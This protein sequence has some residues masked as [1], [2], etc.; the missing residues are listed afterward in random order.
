MSSILLL[1]LFS[2]PIL[3]LLWFFFLLHYLDPTFSTLSTHEP[4]NLVYAYEISAP[5]AFVPFL[6]Y[7]YTA[8][9]T[10]RYFAQERVAIYYGNLTV[11]LAGR[12][13]VQFMALPPPDALPS[14]G[15][16]MAFEY[17]RV[18][19]YSCNPSKRDKEWQF[20]F[21]TILAPRRARD[22]GGAIWMLSSEVFVNY[23]VVGHMALAC[24]IG[25]FHATGAY[26]FFTEFNK[27]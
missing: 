19:F 14:R 1:S 20:S 3:S 27:I 21:P 6:T 4:T 9:R 11:S 2:W 22:V 25:L 7:G 23:I 12:P 16:C 15:D 8:V 17:E 10:A 5:V 24:L 18:P 26:L 13:V